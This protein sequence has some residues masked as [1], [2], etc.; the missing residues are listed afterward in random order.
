VSTATRKLAVANRSRK[1]QLR[2]HVEGICSNSVT[3]KSR[4]RVTESH[5]KW[6]HSMNEG[7]GIDHI[8]VPINDPQ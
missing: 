4:L 1:H 8:P 6:L 5:W 7:Y 3:S 2:T